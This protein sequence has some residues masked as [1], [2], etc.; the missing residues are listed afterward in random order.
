MD[1]LI[2]HA[3]HEDAEAIK[4][5][6]KEALGYDYPLEL[7]YDKLKAALSDPKMRIYVAEIN[8]KI[9][10][11][12]HAQDY[13]VLYASHCKDILGLAVD[14]HYQRMGI[15][16]ELMKAVE[17]WAEETGADCVRLVSGVHRQK[18]HKFYQACGYE[19][20]KEQLNFKK[21]LVRG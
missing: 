4:K 11:Y 15:G 16:K 14:P 1:I 8:G 6:N 12:V 13:D 10:G 5:L 20:G 17:A 2:H 3:V 9:A 21:I 19:C 18:A 7:T